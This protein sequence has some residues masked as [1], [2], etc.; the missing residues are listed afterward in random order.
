[1]ANSTR[2]VDLAGRY[3]QTIE[4]AFPSVPSDIQAALRQRAGASEVSWGLALVLAGWQLLKRSDAEVR[5]VLTETGVLDL[6]NQVQAVAVV[7]PES[8]SKAL[9]A[10]EVTDDNFAGAATYLAEAFNALMELQKGAVVSWLGGVQF[11]A[12]ATTLSERFPPPARAAV[13][14]EAAADLGSAK[15][16]PTVSRLSRADR[17]DKADRPRRAVTAAGSAPPEP[18][19]PPDT[20]AQAHLVR[21]GWS[22]DE[23][24]RVL[25][26]PQGEAGSTLKLRRLMRT[27]GAL[28]KAERLRFQQLVQGAEQAFLLTSTELVGVTLGDIR[29]VR[30]VEPLGYTTGAE[31][32]ADYQTLTVPDRKRWV[33]WILTHEQAFAPEQT[34]PPTPRTP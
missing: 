7:L 3:W 18:N 19:L 16:E 29:D 6:V 17:F 34:G 31:L 11:R 8:F 5:A 10:A 9:N 23:A 21:A 2:L 27:Y 33:R 22:L 12:A 13:T 26:G 25:S 28:S 1:M 32:F 15:P 4:V 24:S 20:L 30:T 14:A